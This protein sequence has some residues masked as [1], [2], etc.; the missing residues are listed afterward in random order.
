MTKIGIVSRAG[1][2]GA[3]ETLPTTP[4]GGID[5]FFARLFERVEAL[6]RDR[7]IAGVGVGVAGFVDPPRERMFYNP[8][9]PWLEGAPLAPMFAHHLNVPVRLDADSNTACLAEY[10]WGAGRGARRFLCVVIG[11]GV[12]GG[13]IVGGE[14]VRLAHGGLGDIGHVIVEPDGPQC[15]AGCHGCAESLIAAPAIEAQARGFAPAET[16]RGVIERAREGDARCAALLQQAGRRLGIALASQAVITF[17][18]RIAI[19][20]GLAEAGDLV[21]RPAAEMFDR[22]I[23]PFY[24]KGVRIVRAELGWKA[25][26]AGAAALAFAPV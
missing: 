13:M 19:G 16:L 4:E 7:P 9:L 20:G 5:A 22:A 3:V 2:V 26:L 15:G 23:G 6:R 10:L 14:I 1:E 8:N 24:R 18:D 12:G 17:P 25:T 11:T 21:V